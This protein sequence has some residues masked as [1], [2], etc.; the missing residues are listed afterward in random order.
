M[1]F[2][3]ERSQ[4]EKLFAQR[5]GYM[6]L[7]LGSMLLC[8]MQII[9][10]FFLIGRE[11]IILIPPNV[12]KSFWVSAQH[13]SAE[14]LSEMTTFFANLRLNITP[15]SAGAQ[16]ESL[17]RYVDPVYY[18]SLKTQLVQEADRVT[19]QHISMAFFPTNV[20]VDSKH[21]KTIIE[22]DIKS[23]VGDTALASKR[24]SY[25]VTYRYDTGRLLVKS[26]EEIKHG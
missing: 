26:F 7:A 3:I 1:R 21:F 20:K 24:V 16:R 5:N 6:M 22:G 17:L 23:F 15:E 11:K 4:L 12:E 2:S 8:L 9:V 10:M 14:Y 13:V 18:N 25:L 19:D